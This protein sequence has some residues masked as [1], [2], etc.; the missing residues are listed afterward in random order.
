LRKRI[1]V[2][3]MFVF[4][5]VIGVTALTLQ[6]T[7]RRVWQRTLR[8]QIE[9][10]L[11]EKTLMFAHRVEADRA[12]SLADIT[13]QEG[14]SAGARATVIDPTGKVLADSE[15][16]PATMEN[17]SQRKEFIAAL[18]GQLAADERMSK[19]VG[20]PFL[21]VA[22]PV[23]G[24]AVRLAYPLP[25]IE[26][27]DRP[28]NRA[29]LWGSLAAVLFALMVAAVAS[30]YV[31]WRLERIVKF[32]ERVAAGD[33]TARIASSSS[34]EIGQ[35]ASAL[36]KTARRVEESYDRVQTSQ[37]ELETLLNSMQ[38]AVIAVGVDG[39]VQWA[40]RGMDR[41][42]HRAPHLNAP[43][44]DSVR[45]PDFLTAIH[46]ASHLKVVTSVRLN[47]LSSG[48]TYD[49]TAAPMPGGGAVAVLR[50]LTET[51]RMEKSR[52]DF[53]AN[54][55]HELRTPLTSIQGYTETLLDH[56]EADT[57]VREF[58]EIIRKNAMRM[59]RLTEDLLTLARVE[60]GE[61]RFEIEPVS[62]EE[63]LQ[64]AAES[65]RELARAHGVGLE[66]EASPATLV[67]ADR[68]AIHQIFSN[69]IEN[70][71]KYAAS[72]KRLVLGARALP[73]G[74]EFY[75]KDFGPGIAS[76][77]LPRLFERFYRVDKARSR[78]S[79]G[80]GLGLAIAK[81]IVLAH[82]GTIRAESELNHGST[83]LFT[84][85]VARSDSA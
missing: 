19:T 21:Y 60:S 15:A 17:H 28:L 37:R 30:Q 14:Q 73:Q 41:L 38:D 66:I 18:S 29:L 8:E 74:V 36:D 76:G 12:H 85:P 81:H 5:L 82:G 63:L 83:F 31:G 69:L 79:G 10:N 80:T 78:E 23:A 44:I 43:L 3:L 55:S 67:N 33:L 75:V 16:D 26:T 70:G 32:A 4:L 1:F 65:F 50:D 25:E 57:N 7:V 52:R 53:I 61:Q 9:R 71:L 49:V 68:E 48:R 35:V 47:T 64:D 39:R 54:V 51:A 46:D 27:T 24:G 11:K 20:I 45:D 84:L 34:D 58:L 13:S 40:N 6:L 62:C 22:A 56:P 42:L 2:K 59:S 77:H 72:G